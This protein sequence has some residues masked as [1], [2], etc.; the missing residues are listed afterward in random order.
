MRIREGAWG[1][2]AVQKPATAKQRARVRYRE[3]REIRSSKSPVAIEPKRPPRDLKAKVV[4]ISD[5]FTEMRSLKS[6]RVG[7]L[8][9]SEIPI[10]KKE[11]QRRKVR[12][13]AGHG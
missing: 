1:S 4:E 6:K 3:A 11:N 13:R 8:T 9:E 12:Q 2:T 10:E 7:P 5:V